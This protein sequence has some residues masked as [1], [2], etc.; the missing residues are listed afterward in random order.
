METARDRLQALFAEQRAA[1]DALP[2]AQQ[3]EPAS[4]RAERAALDDE[5]GRVRD[6][7]SH[8]QAVLERAD[9]TA[10]QLR[11]GAGYLVLKGTRPQAEEALSLLARRGTGA[12]EFEPLR[13]L[14]AERWRAL[15]P[16]GIPT[17]SPAP[18]TAP[19]R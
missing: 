8:W 15:G 6:A 17:P 7:A 16:G 4:L 19:A 3:D 11:R 9:A 1:R 18:W 10:E 5:L 13:T 12:A 2:P 14:H